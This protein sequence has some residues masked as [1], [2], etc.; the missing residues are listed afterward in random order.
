[1]T[2]FSSHFWVLSSDY[3]MTEMQRGLLNKCGVWLLEWKKIL[4]VFVRHAKKQYVC[5]AVCCSVLQCIAVCCS[6]LQCVAVNLGW[7]CSAREKYLGF[8]FSTY[9]HTLQHTATHC[10]ALQHT[11]MIIWG[12][13]VRHWNHKHFFFGFICS[14][15]KWRHGNNGVGATWSAPGLQ[16]IATR[17]NT[18]HT[19]TY[20]NVL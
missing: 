17:C 8:I 9:Y 12:V 1:M 14:A 18:L 20:C 19:A 4:D 5:V 13:F 2:E 6:V 7:I 10:N 11:A 15:L 16:H 3:S